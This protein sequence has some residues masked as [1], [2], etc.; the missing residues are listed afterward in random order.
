MF[1]KDEAADYSKAYYS[2]QMNLKRELCIM[3]YKKNSLTHFM[4]KITKLGD[5]SRLLE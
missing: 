2:N 4:F 5:I 3:Y 1:E